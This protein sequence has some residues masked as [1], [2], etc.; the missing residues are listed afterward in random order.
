MANSRLMINIKGISAYAL[1]RAIFQNRLSRVFDEILRLDDGALGRIKDRLD[2]YNQISQDFSGLFKGDESGENAKN[3][4]NLQGKNA[5]NEQNLL[6]LQN[7]NAQNASRQALQD[8]KNLANL[9]DIYNKNPQNTPNLQA[10]QAAQSSQALKDRIPDKENIN[11][12]PFS[13]TTYYFDSY[14]LTKYFDDKLLWFK[15]FGDVAQH[16]LAPSICKSRLIWQGNENNILLKLDKDRHFGF[17]KD[18]FKF[19]DKKPQAVWRGAAF[20][21]NRAEFLRAYAGREF[22][23]IADA[24]ASRLHRRAN[25]LGKRAQMGFRYIIA[26]EGNDVA[27]NLKWAMFSNSLVIATEMRC[28]TWFM[29][30]R[31]RAG[32]HFV[33]CDNENLGDIVEHYNAHLNEARD[34]IE[35][36]HRYVAQFLDEKMEFYI[37]ILVLAKYFYFSGQM[38][39]PS[40]ILKFIKNA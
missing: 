35:C 10:P 3:L 5:Q 39:L 21:Q 13:K 4:A 28:E 19:E 37:G 20:Q 38:E 40:G 30:G 8:A 7:K 15:K 22:C 14:E 6:N 33:L 23:D 25:Y 24:R 17:V 1:P 29:E 2:Y 11:K 31:L 18:T 26:L 27:S 36:A 16:L 12:F 9:Q 32:E 34:I